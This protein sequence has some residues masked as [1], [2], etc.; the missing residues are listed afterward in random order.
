MRKLKIIEYISLDGIIQ[1]GGA[2][3]ED[4]DYPYGGWAFPFSDPAAGAAIL[5]AHGERFDLLL[6]RRTYDIWAQHWPKAKGGPMA[7][8]INAATKYI[9]T[10]R[11]DTLNWGPSQGVGPNVVEDVRKIKAQDGPDLILWGSSTLTPMLLED[12]L[13]DDILLL[14]CPVLLGEGKRFFS[15]GN[16]PREL[17]LHTSKAVSTG[18][19]I[20]KYTPRGSLRTGSFA[21]ASE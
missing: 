4:G 2:P 16:P 5:D 21:A 14:I 12:G 17:I 6:G 7:G 1:A 13:A 19:L 8:P 9:A 10:H 3:D 11:P 20:N 15:K 18:L